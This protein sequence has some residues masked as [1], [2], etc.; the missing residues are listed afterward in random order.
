MLHYVCNNRRVY[1]RFL[2]AFGLEMETDEDDYYSDSTSDD[3]S[4]GSLSSQISTTSIDSMYVY[5]A[6]GNMHTCVSG[7]SHF[8]NET[9][10]RPVLKFA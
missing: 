10:E 8:V 6:L 7:Y 5:V 1:Y 9:I 2:N 3:H 4:S